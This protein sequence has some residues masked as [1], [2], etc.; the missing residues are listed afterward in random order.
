MDINI[1]DLRTDIEILKRIYD[2]F[3]S[4]EMNRQDVQ[5]RI[6]TFEESIPII[7]RWLRQVEQ[8]EDRRMIESLLANYKVSLDTLKRAVQQ[9]ARRRKTRR[10]GRRGTRKNGK[11]VS[12]TR[13][14]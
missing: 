10:G 12:K 14:H 2:K 7:E 4:G 6:G 8:P 13:K 1:D 5:Y 11:K 9:G 3:R